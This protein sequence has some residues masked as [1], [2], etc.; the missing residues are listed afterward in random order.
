MLPVGI[1][2]PPEK[3]KA[4]QRRHVLKSKNGLADCSKNSKFAGRSKMVR[5]KE[6]KKSRARSVLG[7]MRGLD[8]FADAADCR[9]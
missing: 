6:A 7:L 3:H 4:A 9:F 2:K 8:L 5:C 1:E